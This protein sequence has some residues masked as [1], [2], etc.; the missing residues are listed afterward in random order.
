MTLIERQG[1]SAGKPPN[2][3][4]PIGEG[5]PVLVNRLMYVPEKYCRMLNSMPPSGVLVPVPTSPLPQSLSTRLRSAWAL[6]A[7]GGGFQKLSCTIGTAMIPPAW[8]LC[9]PA[10]PG[11]V[12]RAGLMLGSVMI[13]PQ[14]PL[15]FGR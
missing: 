6:D 4:G 15:S 13:G 2:V 9:V 5:T 11:V 12:L 14:N 8:T 3:A 10:N 1:R 7:V